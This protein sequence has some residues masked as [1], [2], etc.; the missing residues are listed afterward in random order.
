[1]E[2]TRPEL[3][4]R[5]R[6]SPEGAPSPEPIPPAFAFT[7]PAPAPAPAPEP[8]LELNIPGTWPREEIMVEAP[9]NDIM[10]FP[11]FPT[12]PTRFGANLY[13][14]VTYVRDSSYNICATLC[15]RIFHFQGSGAAPNP[16]PSPIPTPALPTT[17]TTLTAPRPITTAPTEEER[18]PK[19]R[20][21][22][23]QQSH[24]VLTNKSGTYALP[25]PDTSDDESGLDDSIGDPM[26]IDSPVR[27]K[28][29]DVNAV[30]SPS[31]PMDIDSPEPQASPSQSPTLSPNSAVATFAAQRR[32]SFFPNGNPYT[33]K[34][35]RARFQ[36]TLAEVVTEPSQPVEDQ[37]TESQPAELQATEPQAI[38]IEAPEAQ[39][40]E[41]LASEVQ[42]SEV[43]EPEVQV[44]EASPEKVWKPLPPPK[45]ANIQEFFDHE[46][47][48]SLPGLERLV[49]RPNVTKIYELDLQRR[50]RLRMEQEKAEKER[51][52][53]IRIEEERL[54]IEKEKAEEER[55]ERF[56]LQEERYNEALRPLG[57]R[58]PRSSLIVP[59]DDEWDQ[60]VREAM[61]TGFC[62]Q[63]KWQ[64]AVHR[65]G[66]E[67]TARDFGRLIPRGAWLNDNAIQSTLV[68]LATYI[69]DAAGVSPKK[70]TP[71]CVALSS[72]YWSNYTRDPRNNVYARGLKRNWG[73]TPENFLDI[74]TVLIPVNNNSH[75]TILVVR[76]SRRTFA[77]VDSFQSDGGRHIQTLAMWKREFLKDKYIPSEWRQEKYTVPTQTNGW[78]CGM[79]VITNS[80]YLALGLDPS[81]YSENQL[82]LQRRR[83]A[84][85]LLNGGFTGPFDL[86]AL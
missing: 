69:N 10:A 68:H 6:F 44:A 82:P 2:E 84:A 1:M 62:P 8:E 42:A 40:S 9:E 34:S 47:E 77:Y 56:R 22:D 53:R 76:P 29:S 60:K 19:R 15:N 78:D 7:F 12:F 39:A 63:N 71:K 3:F 16:T 75:W 73:M 31:S 33:R 64:G 43:Q 70:D 65:D 21:L 52:E 67:I 46:D 32:F 24:L 61:E 38:E 20:R 17:P 35:R 80:I 11:T 28:T 13:N 72:Q 41:V 83:I 4:H 14:A 5:P 58:R 48:F 51:Q 30:M 86:S 57:L 49:L 55:L 26:D 25:S 79:F 45:F 18:S 81:C 23:A 66:V 36:Q 27:A 54:R 74:D 37:S 85:M 50:E 59:L